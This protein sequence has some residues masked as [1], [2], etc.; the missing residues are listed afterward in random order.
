MWNEMNAAEKIAHVA[1]LNAQIRKMCAIV[2]RHV[3]RVQRFNAAGNHY[4]AAR[5]G[6]RVAAMMDRM[7]LH[8]E[9]LALVGMP[10]KA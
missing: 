6:A 9:F 3:V 7:H 5:H 1:E 4:T 10:Y 8:L 2:D